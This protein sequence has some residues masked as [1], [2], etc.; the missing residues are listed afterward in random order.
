MTP[1]LKFDLGKGYASNVLYL[2]VEMIGSYS[3]HESDANLHYRRLQST[4]AVVLSFLVEKTDETILPACETS[5]EP[6]VLI[7]PLRKR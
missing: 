5:A 2:E 6:R 7:S 3:W 1:C 4:F